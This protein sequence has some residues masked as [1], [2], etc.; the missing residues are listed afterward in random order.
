MYS[1]DELMPPTSGGSIEI[2][3]MNQIQVL[4]AP[5][6]T[7]TTTAALKSFLWVIKMVQLLRGAEAVLKLKAMN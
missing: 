2:M 1:Q 3:A 7:T 5:S 4:V 6:S